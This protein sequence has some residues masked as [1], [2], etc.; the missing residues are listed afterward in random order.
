MHEKT[1]LLSSAGGTSGTNGEAANSDGLK[2][3]RAGQSVTTAFGADSSK[4]PRSKATE[5]EQPARIGR[6]TYATLPDNIELQS[7][8]LLC[9]AWRKI[10]L[11]FAP[12]LHPSAKGG[13]GGIP[14]GL[15]GRAAVLVSGPER[16][17]KAM[18]VAAAGRAVGVEVLEVDCRYDSTYLPKLC[19]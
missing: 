5:Q 7:G 9:G 17:G 14:G 8:K 2:T 16:G 3:P 10:A 13:D 19:V 18:E 4:S 11:Q 1:V 15:R 12:N 6:S